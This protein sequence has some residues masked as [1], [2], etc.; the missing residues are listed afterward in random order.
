LAERDARALA[1][2]IVNAVRRWRV[3]DGDAD[4]LTLVVIDVD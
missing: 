4:D 2:E 1:D 3:V